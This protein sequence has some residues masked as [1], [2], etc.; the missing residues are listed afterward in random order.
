MSCTCTLEVNRKRCGDGDE[1]FYVGYA[2]VL[3]QF[4]FRSSF[5]SAYRVLAVLV[6]TDYSQLVPDGR[7]SNR[8]GV[9]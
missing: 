6:F 4:C 3:K 9:R 5:K 1:L 8:E 7:Y 2:R